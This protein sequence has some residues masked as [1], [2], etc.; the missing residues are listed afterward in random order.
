MAVPSV[1]P[2]VG[3]VRAVLQRVVI[4]LAVLSAVALIVW[5]DNEGYT[6]NSD[7]AVDLLDCVL[8]RDRLPLDHRLRRHHAGHRRGAAW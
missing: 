2:I 1:A 8:L 3:P 5:F 6:D 4:A 7:G